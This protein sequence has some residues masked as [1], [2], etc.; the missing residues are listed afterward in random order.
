ME[1]DSLRMLCLKFR[2]IDEKSFNYLLGTRAL[3]IGVES[4]DFDNDK[5]G[6][7]DRFASFERSSLVGASQVHIN[8]WDEAKRAYAQRVLGLLRELYL[9]RGDTK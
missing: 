5:I 2:E 7:P 4:I 9:V 3:E 6:G 1:R 8:S